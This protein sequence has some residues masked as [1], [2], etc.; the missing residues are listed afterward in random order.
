[1]RRSLL[2][3]LALGAALL[4]QP[5][6]AHAQTLDGGW[7]TFSWGGAPVDGVHAFSI[8]SANPFSVRV[9]DGFLIGDV[10][11]LNWSG[12][13]VGSLTGSPI[14]SGGGTASGCS[15]GDC[16]W[17][18]PDLSKLEAVLAAGTYDFLIDVVEIPDGFSGGAAFVRA[19][20]RRLA[21]PEPA[22]LALLGSGLM[23]LGLVAR[24]R[25]A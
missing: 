8:T 19:D 16:A 9:V 1:M 13:A 11:R 14:V 22:T 6:S 25:S 24:R 15:D 7:L 12:S 23:G 3:S 20:T 17:A 4:A 5:T 10:F 18:N 21:V 2:A